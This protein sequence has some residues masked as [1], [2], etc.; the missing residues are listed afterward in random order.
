MQEKP[1]HIN[2]LDL[3][4]VKFE[5]LTITK[6]KSV[7]AIYLQIENVAALTYLLKIGGTSSKELSDIA[8]EIW[9]CL[10]PNQIPITVEYLPNTF[11]YQAD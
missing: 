9:D 2:V 10:I 8:K 6:W 11:N 1:K 3:I 7:K 4:A 5:I